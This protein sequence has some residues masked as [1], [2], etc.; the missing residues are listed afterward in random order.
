M[1]AINIKPEILIIDD[2]RDVGEA[3][4]VLLSKLGYNS[5]FF[6]SVDRGKEYFEKESNPIVFLDIHMPRTSGLDVLPYFKNLNPATQVIMM[7][8]E[9]D[10]NNVVTSLTHKASDFLLK[11]FS[12]QTVRIAVQRALDYYTLLKEKEAR[13]ESIL[14]DLRLASKI[15]KKILSVPDLSPL[16]VAVDNTPASF[17]SGDFYVL[18]KVG[19]NVLA[20]LGDIEDHGVTSGLI[21]LL[22]TSVAREAYKE[23]P[24]PSHILKRMNAEL[25]Q[26]IGTHSLTAAVV[27][28]NLS[29]KTITYARG[30]HPFPALYEKSGQKLLNEKSGQLLGIMDTMEFESHEISYSP[31]DVLFLYSD[32]L[33]NNLS[34]PLFVDLAELRKKDAE[35]SEYEEK[36][37]AFGKASLPTRE[38]RDDSSYLLIR[39]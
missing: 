9:R 25:S 24:N 18:S 37:K 19:D 26:E 14:R 39:F 15:Q 21:G 30:G 34:S 20:L 22:M 6:D 33:L 4:E 31:G 7:T 16:Q 11:P 32:G 28:L 5:T 3:L 29:K 17:V 38:F 2:D 8:G 13:D 1:T 35:I 23:D 10:I 12:L 36:I 27:V